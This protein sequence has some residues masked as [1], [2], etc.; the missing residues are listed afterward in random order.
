MTRKQGIFVLVLLWLQNSIYPASRAPMV[1]LSFLLALSLPAH[2]WTRK[3][4]NVDTNTAL[5]NRQKTTQKTLPK[6]ILLM[7]FRLCHCWCILFKKLRCSY[8]R[9]SS[10]LLVGSEV[11]VGTIHMLL[12]RGGQSSSFLFGDVSRSNIPT[13]FTPLNFMQVS[14]YCLH[15]P[16]FT[17]QSPANLTSHSHSIQT[18]THSCTN[19]HTHSEIHSHTCIHSQAQ[20]TNQPKICH[21]CYFS[22]ILL[23]T[24]LPMTS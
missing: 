24:L 23:L 6:N 7:N 2:E 18:K 11:W 19:T 16:I 21:T 22:P 4:T 10:F 5:G 12:C 17:R 13:L 9:W 15:P 20:R 8:C 3:E 1:C 14:L